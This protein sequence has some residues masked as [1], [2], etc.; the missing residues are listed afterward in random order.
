MKSLG[1]KVTIIL[2]ASLLVIGLSSMSILVESGVDSFDSEN[3][4]VNDDSARPIESHDEAET[5]NAPS[6][7]NANILYGTELG[8]PYYSEWEHIDLGMEQRYEMGQDAIPFFW[9]TADG[10]DPDGDSITYHWEIITKPV[11]SVAVLDDSW[12]PWRLYPDVPGYYLVS[13][14]VFDGMLWS[15][16]DYVSMHVYDTDFVTQH[17]G[18]ID[19]YDTDNN[20]QDDVWVTPENFA[21]V[22]T[23]VEISTT[24]PAPVSGFHPNGIYGIELPVVLKMSNP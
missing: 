19:A 4:L 16:P 13:V 6:V 21:D 24:G 10:S 15:E 8:T 9:L 18:R 5:N 1:S 11:G 22:F 3:I 12:V 17:D 23:S 2:I 20:G 14:V 7:D